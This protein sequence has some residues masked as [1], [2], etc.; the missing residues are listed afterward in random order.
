MAVHQKGDLATAMAGYRR[1]LAEHPTNVRALSLL[2]TVCLQ[3]GHADEA[4]THLTAA[5]S[6][7][8]RDIGSLL[9]LGYAFM[10]RGHA[11]EAL[12][13]FRRLLKLD[14]KNVDALFAAGNAFAQQ[15]KFADAETSYRKAFTLAPGHLDAV[16]NYA[17]VLCEQERHAE[18]IAFY[19][20]VLARV[21]S[22]PLAATNRANALSTAGQFDLAAAAYRQV[23]VGQ[24]HNAAAWNGL[25]LALLNRGD[26]AGAEAAFRSAIAHDPAHAAEMS[27]ALAQA[28]TRQGREDEAAAIWQTATKATDPY[29]R[30]TAWSE[31][32]YRGQADCRWDDLVAI[33]AEVRRLIDGG[34]TGGRVLAL[35]RA[36]DA[37]AL[38]L[39][40][41]RR[42][43]R[44]WARPALVQHRPKRKDR[45]TIGYLS[46]D[47]RTHPVALLAAG[48]FECHDPGRFR[49]VGLSTGADDGSAIRTRIAAAFDEFHDIS[50][51]TAFDGAQRVNELGVDIL[52][53]LAGHTNDTGLPVAGYRPAP[54][55]ATW[56]GYPG[57]TGADFIDYLISDTIVTPAGADEFYTEKLVRLPGS[58]QSNDP[59]RPRPTSAPPRAAFGLPETGLVFCSFNQAAKI[60]RQAF[61]LWCDLLRQ[62]PGAVLWLMDGGE[63]VRANIRREA[64]SQGIAADRVVFADKI[65][66]AEHLVRYLHADIFLDSGPYGAHTTASDALWMGCPVVTMPGESFASRVG[67]SLLH[68]V[69]LPDLIANSPAE[70]VSLAMALALNQNYRLN[71][72]AQLELARQTASLFDAKRFTTNLET[73]YG[74][75]WER[76]LAKRPPKPISVS[77]S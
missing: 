37:P 47:F 52:V 9:H 13:Q 33:N 71:Y 55:Q 74:A 63:N 16:L 11:V 28:V 57:T 42:E 65:G 21:P 53:D 1:V 64:K 8:P 70:Y 39:A 62:S 4:V 73:A 34:I 10:S 59:Q 77:E 35:L 22:H 29:M 18:A 41:A 43:A 75:M 23:L 76:W 15:H 7:N 20:Q 5:L 48:V 24:P 27:N 58:Y 46:P 6:R 61:H 25:G 60:T 45:V 50:K 14:G 40:R 2:G 51:L 36:E 69:G 3:M 26:N 68:A 54:I 38:H 56:L 32:Q 31:L 12:E 44:N 67:A 72:R 19:D 17:N 66:L 49:V 30:A